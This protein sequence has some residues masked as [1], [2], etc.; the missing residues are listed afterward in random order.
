MLTVGGENEIEYFVVTTFMCD[1]LVE[2]HAN[3]FMDPCTWARL[4]GSGFAQRDLCIA[5]AW[6]SSA[7]HSI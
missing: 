6:L 3:R 4:S 7:E 5:H 1:I 2:H